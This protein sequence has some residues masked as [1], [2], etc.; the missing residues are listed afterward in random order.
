M[1]KDYIRDYVTEMFRRYAHAGK[2]T[3][4][5]A[6][7]KIYEAEIKKRWNVS[8]DIAVKQAEKA[9]HDRTPYLLD[10]LAVDKT[11]SLL[12]KN[13]RE[14]I[15]RAVTDVYFTSPSQLLRKGDVSARVRAF[16]LDLPCSEKQAYLYLRQARRLCA[17]IRGL[18]VD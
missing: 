18:S 8:P 1:K 5:E 15:A 7:R 13:G 9:V 6:K 10:I 2:P 4:E 3:Y 14:H 12:R 11:M 17:A 16:A